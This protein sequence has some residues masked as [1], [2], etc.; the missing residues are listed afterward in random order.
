MG[1]INYV[2]VNRT[3][4]LPSSSADVIATTTSKINCARD[5]FETAGCSKFFFSDGCNILIGR[6]ARSILPANTT[7]T[8]GELS[9]FCPTNP[10]IGSFTKQSSFNCRFLTTLQADD[11]IESILENNSGDSAI[12]KLGE[13]MIE[14]NSENATFKATSTKVKMSSVNLYGEATES[15]A[16]WTWIKFSILTHFRMGSAV[17]LDHE[18]DSEPI[19]NSRSFSVRSKGDQKFPVPGTWPRNSLVHQS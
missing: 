1:A 11:L 8:A 15:Q 5:C 3:E 4:Y 19:V 12:V 7:T 13:W 10:F 16:A 18:P 6:A 9:K 14:K 17:Q 2:E